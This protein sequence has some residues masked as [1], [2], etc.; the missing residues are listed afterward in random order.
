MHRITFFFRAAFAVA[1]VAITRLATIPIHAEPLFALSDK[2]AHVAAFVLLAFL[3]D[4]AW[5][6][7]GFD[8][9]KIAPLL[10]YG[11]LIEVIQHFLPY[12]LF[13]VLDFVADGVGVAAYAVVAPLTRRIPGLARQSRPG[14][15]A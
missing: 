4:H 5:P 9:T 10:A 3:I 1:L 7:S 6:Q 12:R 15:Q 13:S 14:H 2:V 8:R 11:L